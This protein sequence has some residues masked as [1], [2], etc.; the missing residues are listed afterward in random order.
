MLSSNP[1]SQKQARK[2]VLLSQGIHRQADAGRGLPA[3]R[4]VVEHLGYVQIDTISVVERAHHH[5][6]WS[7]TQGYKQAHLD[8]LLKDKSVF[9]YWSH[10]AAY[11]PMRDYRFSLPR[12]RAFVEGELHWHEKDPKLMAFVLDRIRAEG[13]LQARDFENTNSP[14]NTAWWGWKPAKRALEQLFMQ[15]E[16]MVA[17]RQGFQKVYDLTERVLPNDLNTREPDDAEFC[18]HLIE[19]YLQAN[20]L[21]KAREIAY[22]RKGLKAPVRLRCQAL[23]E[24][25]RLCETT[26]A[27]ERYYALSSFEEI[28]KKP[29]SRS[30]VLILSPFDN[31]LIQRD[32]MRH[33]FNFDYQIECYKPAAKREY[34]YFVL[35]ILWGQNFAARMDAKIDRKTGIFI[36]RHLHID[37]AD[38]QS[39]IADFKTAL[40]EFMLFNK[41]SSITVEKISFKNRIVSA[42]EQKKWLKTLQ[43]T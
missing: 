8:A 26:V 5:T 42:M 15:G 38:M 25:G 24:A 12:K 1:L 3:V 40:A 21:G 39:F 32:R 22:L 11:L 4:H 29:L 41:A 17:Y 2:L 37:V 6:L 35:P 13:P 18:D 31:V 19:R 34:G 23:L 27:G 36:V 7:R 33:L 20:G 28:L 30:K 14:A 9:E 16:L 10:A 43:N